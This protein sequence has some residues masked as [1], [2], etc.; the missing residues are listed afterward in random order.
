MFTTCQN[1]FNVVVNEG[2]K[3]MQVVPKSISSNTIIGRIF[4]NKFSYRG[5]YALK[6]R[7]TNKIKSKKEVICQGG[8]TL[9]HNNLS[10]RQNLLHHS[11]KVLLN[12]LAC[13]DISIF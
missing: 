4:E 9:K 8:S 5:T 2:Y 11:E 10:S 7:S 1:Y 6:L 12:Y 13:F 3:N